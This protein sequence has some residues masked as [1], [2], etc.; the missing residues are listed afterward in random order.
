MTGIIYVLNL[1]AKDLHMHVNKYICLLALPGSDV[2]SE[3]VIREDISVARVSKVLRREFPDLRI[4]RITQEWVPLAECYRC[5][6]TIF[7]G[8]YHEDRIA[9]KN[10]TNRCRDC[11]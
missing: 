11:M 9:Q 2:P 4:L 3:S 5:G 10:G 6:G 1:S 8:Q 7:K